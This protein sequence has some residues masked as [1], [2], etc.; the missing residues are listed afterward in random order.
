MSEFGIRCPSLS[1]SMS[2]MRDPWRTGIDRVV[3][4]GQCQ[5]LRGECQA[6]VMWAGT[7]RVAIPLLSLTSHCPVGELEL[8]AEVSEKKTKVETGGVSV[9]PL[10]LLMSEGLVREQYCKFW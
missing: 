9:G 8:D 4:Q 10:C 2:L 3:A 1:L 7:G 6:K 5:L